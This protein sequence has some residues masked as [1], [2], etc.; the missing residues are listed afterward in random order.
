MGYEREGEKRRTKLSTVIPVI[1]AIAGASFGIY[2]WMSA[3]DAKKHYSEALTQ[4]QEYVQT[5]ET[6]D[7]TISSLEEQLA[8]CSEQEEKPNYKIGVLNLPGEG[9]LNDTRA[10]VRSVLGSTYDKMSNP[11]GYHLLHDYAYKVYDAQGILQEDMGKITRNL[12]DGYSFKMPELTLSEEAG[13]WRLLGNYEKKDGTIEDFVL[14][15]ENY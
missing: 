4:N 12:P 14:K 15:Q 10:Y 5:I 9:M 11:A 3:D 2:Q 13:K 1:I 7:A 6:K 8:K